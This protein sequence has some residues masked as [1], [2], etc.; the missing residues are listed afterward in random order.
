LRDIREYGF[1]V[2]RDKIVPV[3]DC[4]KACKA[5]FGS[6]AQSTEENVL[7]A[8]AAYIETLRAETGN[9]L[10]EYGD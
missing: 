10:H 3:R 8:I 5:V 7:S 4:D 6:G 9:L 2:V 1:E